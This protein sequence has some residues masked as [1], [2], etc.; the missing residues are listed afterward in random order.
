MSFENKGAWRGVVGVG[1]ADEV[2]HR[3]HQVNNV[4]HIQKKI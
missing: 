3:T 1:A 4:E 2:T